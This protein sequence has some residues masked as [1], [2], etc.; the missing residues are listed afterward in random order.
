MLPT[1]RS[2]PVCVTSFWCGFFPHYKQK[3]H[4]WALHSYVQILR[5][6]QKWWGLLVLLQRFVVWDWSQ[7]PGYWVPS[8]CPHIGRLDEELS[9]VEGRIP[10]QSDAIRVS[11][12][13]GPA[14][15]FP[16]HSFLCF[17]ILTGEYSLCIPLGFIR[18]FFIQVYKVHWIYSH[19]ITLYL[20]FLILTNGFPRH[21]ASAFMK[22]VHT[23]VYVA[24]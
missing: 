3:F 7:T 24:T 23:L 15:V 14:T 12:G 6:F 5:N 18:T 16:P 2:M 19:H 13:R 17:Y 11:R 21:F 9:Y 20:P 1:Q 22:Y 8:L 10:L 4:Q